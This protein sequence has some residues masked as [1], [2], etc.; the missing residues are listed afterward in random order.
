MA[1]GTDLVFQRFHGFALHLVLDLKL[2]DLSLH[3]RFLFDELFYKLIVD[4]VLNQ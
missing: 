3:F 2:L 4:V 1:V